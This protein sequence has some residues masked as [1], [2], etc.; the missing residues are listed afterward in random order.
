MASKEHR[1]RG[2]DTRMHAANGRHV[3]ELSVNQLH[4]AILGQDARIAELVV[5]LDRQFVPGS[6]E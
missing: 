6:Y 1:K 5:V 4:A 3:D 2:H